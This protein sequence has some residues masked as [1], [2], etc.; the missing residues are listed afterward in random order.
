MLCC[1]NSL[2][3]QTR[4]IF[5]TDFGGDADDIFGGGAHLGSDEVGTIIKTDEG[6]PEGF[7]QGGGHLPVP[8]IDHHAVGHAPGELL[9]MAG[10]YPHRHRRVWGDKFFRHLAQTQTS[11]VFNPFHAQNHGLAPEFFRRQPLHQVPETLGSHGNHQNFAVLRRG[12]KTAGK[13]HRFRKGHQTVGS[14]PAQL[15]QAGGTRTAPEGH[16]MAQ[17]I[18]IPSQKTA[19]AATPHYRNFHQKT[20][21]FLSNLSRNRS[22]CSIIQRRATL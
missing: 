4:V 21:P 11:A 5:D 14:G 15:L 1:I 16:L 6:P 8:G 20:H 12:V 18:Q 2:P 7:H 9:Y 19:P 3:A 10:A 13:G 22:H 17:G